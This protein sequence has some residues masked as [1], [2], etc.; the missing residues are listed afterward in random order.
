MQWGCLHKLQPLILLHSQSH[1]WQLKHVHKPFTELR[2]LSWFCVSQ[3]PYWCASYPR[4]IMKF[5]SYLPT[6]LFL[7]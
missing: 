7:L 1:H 2:L 3:D 6:H 5:L 4:M